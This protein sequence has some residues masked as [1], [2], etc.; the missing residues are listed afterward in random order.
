MS[1]DAKLTALHEMLC[2][3]LI[4]RLKEGDSEDGKTT[5]ATLNVIRQFLRD[6][7]IEAVADDD[8]NFA[9]LWKE[10]P[11]DLRKSVTKQ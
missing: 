5:P 8:T 2:D 9:D 1:V 6:N 4:E 10:L 7:H 3:E 11:D